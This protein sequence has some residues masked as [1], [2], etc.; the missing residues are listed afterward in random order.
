M[1]AAMVAAQGAADEGATTAKDSGEGMN[2]FGRSSQRR[3]YGRRGD[4]YGRRKGGDGSGRIK[5]GK[6]RSN[7]LGFIS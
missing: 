6:R 4:G 5:G 7:N 3:G 2:V 1:A